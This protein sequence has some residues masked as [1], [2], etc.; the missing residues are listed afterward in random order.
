MDDLPLAAYSRGTVESDKDLDEHAAGAAAPASATL[1]AAAAQVPGTPQPSLA[2]GTLD[3]PIAVPEG[4]PGAIVRVPWPGLGRARALAR[5][6]PRLVAGGGFVAMIL[7]GLALLG[8]GKPAPSAASAA[9]TAGAP[10]AAPIAADPGAASMI[11]TGAIEGTY[12]FTGNGGQSLA[13]NA[14]TAAWV[15]TLQNVL[16]LDG[17]VDRGTR[18]TDA[19]LVLTWGLM[20]DGKLVTFTSKSGECTIGMASSPKSVSGSFACR[21]IKSDDGKLSVGATGTYRT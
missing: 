18:M 12:S 9:A 6:N 13:G 17:P 4:E 15:D 11:L 3:Q 5:R 7:I 8:G 16:T 2:L 1:S 21:K 14:V 19:G 10:T 20:L